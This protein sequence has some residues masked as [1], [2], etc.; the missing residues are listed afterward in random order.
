M[1]SPSVQGAAPPFIEM[2]TLTYSADGVM[3][4]PAPPSTLTW[5]P[6]A[7]SGAARI[8]EAVCGLETT[9]N[10]DVKMINDKELTHNFLLK[11]ENAGRRDAPQRDVLRRDA[12]PSSCSSRI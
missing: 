5:R 2:A 9:T 10:L 11:E 12:L 4:A 3:A 6:D 1:E 8:S 7:R